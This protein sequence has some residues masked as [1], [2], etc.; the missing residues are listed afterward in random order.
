MNVRNAYEHIGTH[1]RKHIHDNSVKNEG[2][3]KI[4]VN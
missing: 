1:V 4:F 3:C 2:Q